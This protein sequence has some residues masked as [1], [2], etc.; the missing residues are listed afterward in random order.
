MVEPRNHEKIGFQKY[1]SSILYD[2]EK[3][4]QFDGMI[5]FEIQENLGEMPPKKLAVSN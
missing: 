2:V 1:M 4:A 3:F 5:I